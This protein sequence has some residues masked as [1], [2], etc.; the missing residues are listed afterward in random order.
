MPMRLTACLR[1]SGY[2]AIRNRGC[3]VDVHG[4]AEPTAK[5]EAFL[6]IVSW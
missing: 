1:I 4:P 5:L 3:L 6:E 2:N